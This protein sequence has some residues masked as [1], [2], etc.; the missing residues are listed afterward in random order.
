MGAIHTLTA[1]EARLVPGRQLIVLAAAVL[2]QRRG[3]V[4][5]PIVTERLKR[6]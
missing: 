1:R 6:P 5:R 2:S 4:Q 3:Q